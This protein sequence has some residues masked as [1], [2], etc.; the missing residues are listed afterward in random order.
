MSARLAAVRTT[1]QITFGLI[2]LPHTKPAL[3]IA[4]NTVPVV[5]PA[6]VVQISTVAL[7]QAGMGTVRM[8]PA[9]DWTC[10]FRPLNRTAG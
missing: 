2:P 7:T 6:A 8:C 5:I 3:L 4:R 9:F 1:P 10:Q